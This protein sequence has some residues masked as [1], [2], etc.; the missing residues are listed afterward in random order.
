M[1]IQYI[2]NPQSYM[3]PIN[4]E[5]KQETVIFC[6]FC[7]ATF[8][9]KNELKKHKEKEHNQIKTKT[10]K[11]SSSVIGN[12]FMPH[13]S[14]FTCEYCYKGFDQSHRLKQHQISHREPIHACTQCSKSFKCQ[15]RLKY[16]MQEHV[17]GASQTC[18]VCLKIFPTLIRLQQHQ[19]MHNDKI[20]QCK[21]FYH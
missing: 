6:G 16:H 1:N 15:Y 3:A 14:K 11:E 20:Y 18:G 12:Q 10:K 13:Q 9:N 21:L 8:Q 17:P 2:I 7:N 4:V 5:V 19:I